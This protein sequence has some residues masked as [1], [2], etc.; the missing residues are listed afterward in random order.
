MNL[1]LTFPFN[2]KPSN[3]QLTA[4]K[5]ISPVHKCSIRIARAKYFAMD[6]LDSK[7]AVLQTSRGPDRKLNI[8]RATPN[9]QP[10]FRYLGILSVFCFLIVDHQPN[11]DPS[12]T[13]LNSIGNTWS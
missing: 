4:H 5:K 12:C 3:C 2:A 1:Y 10:Q 11:F 9:V 13:G 8:P 7:L 6:I